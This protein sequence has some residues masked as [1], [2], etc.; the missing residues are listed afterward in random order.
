MQVDVLTLFPE[1]FAGV[2]N[3]S[4]LK[5][6]QEKNLLSVNLVN[7]RDYSK[8]K[9]RCVDDYPFG[10]GPGM[11]LQVEPVVTAV[12]DI[13]SREEN[14]VSYSTRVILMSPQGKTFNQDKAWELA[15]CSRLVLI[16]GHY[17]GIDERVRILLQ[18][19]EISIGDYILTGGELPAMVVIDAVTRLIPGVLGA[20]KGGKDESFYSGFLEYPQY[21][22][23]RVFRGL[24]VPEVLLSGHHAKIEQWRK[25]QAFLRTRERRPDLLKRFY[26]TKETLDNNFKLP[27]GE[28]GNN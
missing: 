12:E 16:C 8:N 9:H 1:M 20:S 26:L 2:L 25:E 22:R 21:T 24:E 10:G 17:E 14:A 7:I 3:S 5:R 18:P 19:E 23:P 27:A 4:I 6:A 15:K 28:E 13:L 11:V